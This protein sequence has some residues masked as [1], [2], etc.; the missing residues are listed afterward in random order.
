MKIVLKQDG[1]DKVVYCN[2]AK[3]KLCIAK[4]TYGSYEIYFEDTKLREVYY[5][6]DAKY[7]VES[8]L[9]LGIGRDYLNEK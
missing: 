5:L 1:Y 8:L 4:T 9:G 6:E 3:T 7:I 2:K